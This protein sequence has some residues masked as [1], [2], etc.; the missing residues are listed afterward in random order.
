LTVVSKPYV[1]GAIAILT[2]LSCVTAGIPQPSQPVRT[3]TVGFTPDITSA[4]PQ[5][6]NELPPLYLFAEGLTSKD[7]TGKVVP[8]L[9]QS[10]TL[11]G[12]DR[13]YTFTLRPNVLFHNGR[14]MT[15]DDVKF[16][17]ERIKNPETAAFR[18]ADMRQVQSITVVDPRT[19]RITLERPNAAFPA[20]LVGVFIIARESVGADGK[21]VKPI[22]TG[23]F[24]FSEW[25]PGDRLVLQRFPQYWQ[26]G[27]P[28]AEAVVV[29]MISDPTARVN[30]IRSGDLDLITDVEPELVP[31]LARDRTLRVES[32]KTTIYGHITFNMHNPQ[33]PL[34]DVRVR[35]AI[36]YALDKSQLVRARESASAVANNQMYR[37]AEF[38]HVSLPDAFAAR[39][40]AKAQALMK[41]AGVGPFSTELITLQTYERVGLVLQQQLRPIGV[42]VKVTSI[43][44]FATFQA[45]LAK[46]DYGLLSDTGYP[47]DDPSQLFG[48]WETGS[49][50]GLYRGGFSDPALDQMIEAIRTASDPSARQRELRSALD[51]IE[52][53]KVATIIYSGQ[54][55]VWA[56][57]TRLKGFHMGDT[58][59]LHYSGAG[60]AYASVSP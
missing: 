3:I 56:Y 9:A 57:R 44:D 60:L 2:L 31:L 27:L 13:T 10:W 50:S 12:D 24:Q 6:S 15:A 11:S 23:P 45:R 58:S 30:G 8:F 26:P 41:E 16:S 43:P 37:P 55:E 42:D 40:L 14:Q 47:R 49:P 35:R 17:L 53:Q 46:Y 48:F 38:W 7:S 39:D 59:R 4:D 36:G 34:S 54:G 29:R 21:V 32:A 51:F 52:Y 20:I 1:I 5:A 22:G 33:G 25:R 19:V 18:Q 28:K